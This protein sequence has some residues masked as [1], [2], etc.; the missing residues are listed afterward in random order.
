MALSAFVLMS[1]MARAA[2]HTVDDNGREVVLAE[3]AKRVL[4]LAPHITELIDAAGGDTVLIGAVVHSDYPVTAQRLPRVGDAYALDLERIVALKPDLIVAWPD[5]NPRRQLD[6]LRA[7]SI[8]MFYSRPHRLSDI[9]S[10]IERLGVLLDTQPIASAAAT[11]FRA[12]LQK[13]RARYAHRSPVRVFYQI[14]EHPLMTLNAAHPVSEVIELCG[15]KNIF[16][17]LAAHAPHV[18]LEAVLA[19]NPQAIVTTR[20]VPGQFSKYQ[21]GLARWRHWP[22]LI[23]VQRNALFILDAD[24][25]DRPGPRI[26]QGAAQLCSALEIARQSLP[27]G[28]GG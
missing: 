28:K 7:L 26:A 14:S 24:M 15:G 12:A 13:L 19:A 3:P 17:H 10:N 8:P 27:I 6:A 20:T 2:L 5:G 23:A 25:L 21:A 11:K 18:S 22:N 16:A 9:A 1:Q 4:S